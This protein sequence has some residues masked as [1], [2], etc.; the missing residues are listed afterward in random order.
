[1][2]EKF[3]ICDGPFENRWSRSSGY[4]SGI[5][6]DYVGVNVCINSLLIVYYHFSEQARVCVCVIIETSSVHL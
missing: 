4:S 5:A 2:E 6:A 1:M 3:N